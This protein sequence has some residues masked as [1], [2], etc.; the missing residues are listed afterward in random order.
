[1][2]NFKI[3]EEQWYQFLESKITYYGVYRNYDYGPEKDSYVSKISPF[4]SHRVL[5]EYSIIRD[6]QKKYNGKNVYKFIEEVYWRIYWK[7][8]LENRP[9]VW[10][11]FLLKDNEK[12]NYKDY[13]RAINA[14]TDLFFFNEWVEELKGFN[15]LHNHTR[16]W[17]AST[18][19]FNLGLPWK[20]GA[21]FFLEHLYDGDAASNTLSWRWVAGLH[22][23]GKKYLFSPKNLKKFSNNRFIVN[24]INNKQIDLADQYVFEFDNDIF[25]NNM[26]KNSDYLILFE[27]DLHLPT[28][29]NLISNYEE[30]L[31][32]FLNNNQRQVKLSHSVLKFKE[33]LVNEFVTKT[34][35]IQKV[36][37]SIFV[38][39]IKTFKKIDVLYPGIGENLDFLKELQVKD[40]LHINYLVRDEDL[41]AWKYAKK[42]FFNFKKNIPKINGFINKKIYS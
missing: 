11:Q 3:A 15:Y 28:L 34:S 16:M 17:F 39:K 25:K 5:L 31:I 19:I 23:K 7:G 27:N 41:F 9:S 36:E 12:F 10:T 4:I 22:T 42:G 2:E 21:R 13:E 6:V 32:V 33:N 37:S 26:K 24:E 35:N 18:W 29:K 8:W 40:N 30:V 20:L 14:Q 1:M 38:Q